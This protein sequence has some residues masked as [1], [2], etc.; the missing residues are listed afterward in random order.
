VIIGSIFALNG[1][2]DIDYAARV[3]H[4]AWMVHDARLQIAECPLTVIF[5]RW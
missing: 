4:S 3:M 2:R 5:R 1:G